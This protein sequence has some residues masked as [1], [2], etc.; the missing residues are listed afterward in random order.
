MLV[1]FLPG[2]V[3]VC[4]RDQV[5]PVLAFLESTESHLGTRNVFL[6]VF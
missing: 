5:I 2:Y 3:D 4:I 1:I 6:G